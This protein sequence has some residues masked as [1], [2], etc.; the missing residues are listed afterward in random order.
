MPE[1][2]KTQAASPATIIVSLPADAKLRIDGNATQSDSARRT[3][4]TPA[5]EPGSVYA[6]ELTAE[7]VIDGR[8]VTQTQRVTV[9]AG[10]VAE[11]P[12]NFSTQGVASR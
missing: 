10:Q 9:R 5:L 1:L 6:H 12:F 2:K 3:F 11:V 8:T 7:V 4:S